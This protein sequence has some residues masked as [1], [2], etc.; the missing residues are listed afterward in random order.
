MAWQ[1]SRTRRIHLWN[2]AAAV[3]YGTNMVPKPDE[4]K[5]KLENSMTDAKDPHRAARLIVRNAATA[6]L[7][8]L[9][10]DDGTP[11]GSL[12][13]VASDAAGRPIILISS[14]AWHT[15]NL[16]AD[17][18]ASLLFAV[19][20]EYGDALE[21][22]RVTV[23]GRFEASE[24]AGLRARYLAWHVP[25]RDYAGFGDFSIWRMVPERV[26]TVA[27]FGRIESMAADAMLLGSELE[28]VFADLTPEQMPCWRN[29]EELVT[30]IDADGVLL[31]ADRTV[32]RVNFARP[33]GSLTEAGNMISA[34]D[35]SDS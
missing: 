23:L 26:H 11:Y 31:E 21:S 33:A 7:S 12:V 20:G 16:L 15:Q 30:G 32:R 5:G 10:H 8:T 35:F 17:G 4:C 28:G 14:L 27:G 25:A 22:T 2:P 9:Q 24:D 18:R 29:E 34:A 6:T 3:N 1:N 13:N 19:G